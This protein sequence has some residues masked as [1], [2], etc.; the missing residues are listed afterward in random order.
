MI[1]AQ[2]KIILGK[3]QEM[4]SL[5]A[6]GIHSPSK[7][8]L[9]T[10]NSNGLT[11]IIGEESSGKTSLLKALLLH[12]LPELSKQR[13]DAF[14]PDIEYDLQ[15][16][17]ESNGY[18]HT[19]FNQHGLSIAPRNGISPLDL[20]GDVIL[21]DELTTRGEL[22][23]FILGSFSYQKKLIGTIRVDSIPA[24]I[25][26]IIQSLKG[27][28]RHAWETR[29]ERVLQ[30]LIKIIMTTSVEREDGSDDV[31]YTELVF[32]PDIIESLKQ[33]KIE[34]MPLE[35]AKYYAASN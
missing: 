8:L 24:A 18:A 15:T 27:A 3:K 31:A 30:H 9:E 13:I 21:M 1:N 28:D 22:N 20:G 26:M 16:F 11:L 7:S 34:D 10:F 29:V 5:E 35:I 4:R 17:A 33:V 12:S 6:L 32:T 23:T 25:N 14:V 19:F 2:N